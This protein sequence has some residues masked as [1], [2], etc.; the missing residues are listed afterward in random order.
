MDQRQRADDTFL[1][2]LDQ[3]NAS[4]IRVSQSNHGTNWAPKLFA[5]SPNRK[6][7]A[8]RDFETAMARL[9]AEKKIEVKNF[10]RASRPLPGLVKIIPAE[11]HAEPS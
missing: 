2:L 1:E 7:F 8:Q 6:G 11:V 3:S 4:G 10:G 9:L 5:A